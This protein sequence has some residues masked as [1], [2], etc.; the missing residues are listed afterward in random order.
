MRHPLTLAALIALSGVCL[1][2][3]GALAFPCAALPSMAEAGACSSLWA[4][5]LPADIAATALEA[6]TVLDE[7]P[8]NWRPVLEPLFRP[9]V[10]DCRS[11]REATLR[12]A[13]RIGELTGVHYD[14]ARRHPCMNALEALAEKKVSCT[15]QSILLVCALRSVGIPARAVGVWT[16]GHVRGNH[17]WVEAWFEGG[18]HMIEFNEAAFNTPWVMEGVGMLNPAHPAQ[19]VLAVQQGGTQRFPTV[20]NP[21]AG[22][23]AEDVTERYLALARQWYAEHGVPEGF[24]KLMVDVQPRSAGARHILLEDEAGKEIARATLPTTADDFRRF[25]T[26]LLPRAATGYLRLEGTKQRYALNANEAPAH[27][28]TLRLSPP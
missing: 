8:C 16:W 23:E 26:L 4:E 9:V 19:R 14:R 27:I 28:V 1:P 2:F 18:W 17:T 12:I 10:A 21:H 24:Q 22:V 6:T 11:A 3:M 7:T 15:G 13:S 25:A 20:W 5:H